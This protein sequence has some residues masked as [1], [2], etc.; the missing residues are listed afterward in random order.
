METHP[1]EFLEEGDFP[2]RR[3]ELFLHHLHI[4]MLL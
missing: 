4:I 2:L 1:V 3:E